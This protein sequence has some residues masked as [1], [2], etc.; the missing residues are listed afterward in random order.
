M[1][2]S[3]R[4]HG[5]AILIGDGA[6][7]TPTCFVDPV[8]G[9]VTV[10]PRYSYERRSGYAASKGMMTHPRDLRT[11]SFATSLTSYL[12]YDGLLINLKAALGA[13]ST[14]GPSGS[15]YTH[16]VARA[17][18][19]AAM[20]LE[21]V[22]SDELANSSTMTT[23]RCSTWA[24][25]FPLN[26]P[27]TVQTSYVALNYAA[28]TTHT[29]LSDRTDRKIV[30]TND[31][32][33]LTLNAVDLLA[34]GVVQ[35]LVINGENA[36][37][38]RRGFGSAK[39]NAIFGTSQGTITAALTCHVDS[40]TYN[41]YR[42]LHEAGTEVTLVATFTAA[43]GETMTV[44]LRGAIV[45]DPVEPIGA[46]TGP[47]EVTINLDCRQTASADAITIVVVN[48]NSSAVAN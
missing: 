5:L 36:Q 19:T 40:T 23:A 12:Y 18:D 20:T 32:T 8:G 1:G 44:T 11:A 14:T 41:D 38:E 43:T 7:V 10:E 45:S 47:I 34:A 28:E 27:A 6:S 21:V 24:L 29:A 46:D 33:V 30:S 22:Y 42:A 31:C 4:G 25:N 16:T 35:S 3:I 39:P 9:S 37:F 2:T 17:L 15:D 26:E 48:E 13:V